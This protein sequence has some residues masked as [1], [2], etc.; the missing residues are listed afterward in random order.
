[1]T[2]GKYTPSAWGEIDN[3]T[4]S[5][6]KVHRSKAKTKIMPKKASKSSRSKLVKDDRLFVG[7]DATR[8]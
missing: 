6:L 2:F 1:M 5:K 3:G 8:Y 4:P 7:V